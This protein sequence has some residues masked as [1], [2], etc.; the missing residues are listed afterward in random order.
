MGEEDK[1]GQKISLLVFIFLSLTIVPGKR[2]GVLVCVEEVGV[3]IYVI[4]LSLE[5]Q[6][7]GLGS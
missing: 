4:L 5:F 6:G 1:K 2:G 7:F 3:C